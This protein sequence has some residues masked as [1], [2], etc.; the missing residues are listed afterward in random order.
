MAQGILTSSEYDP[1]GH[2]FQAMQDGVGSARSVM[3]QHLRHW[4]R[5]ALSQMLSVTFLGVRGDSCVTSCSANI[6]PKTS[7]FLS[8][9]LWDRVSLCSSVLKLCGWGW[10]RTHRDLPASPVLS[11]KERASR[12]ALKMSL[13]FKENKLFL[14]SCHQ[15]NYLPWNHLRLCT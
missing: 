13:A 8:V 5:S 11:L 4:M 14:R 2:V 6:F 7:L 10:L 15:V 3:A 9:S 1:G 12:L